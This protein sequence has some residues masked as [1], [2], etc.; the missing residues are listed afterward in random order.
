MFIHKDLIRN[1]DTSSPFGI[2]LKDSCANEKIEVEEK[3]AAEEIN[4][5]LNPEFNDPEAY[6]WL[7]PLYQIDLTHPLGSHQ[8]GFFFVMREQILL[9]ERLAC[10]RSIDKS[11]L[12]SIRKELLRILHSPL[13]QRQKIAEIGMLLFFLDRDSSI[14]PLAESSFVEIRSK[15]IVAQLKRMKKGSAEQ[16]RYLLICFAKLMITSNQ[17]FNRGG[18]AALIRMLQEPRFQLASYFSPEHLEHILTVSHKILSLPQLAQLF[19]KN[20][21]IH[22]TMKLIVERVLGL[23]SEEQIA[24]VHAVWTCLVALFFNIRQKGPNCYAIGSILYAIENSLYKVASRLL[25]FLETGFFWVS[26][27]TSIPLS[28]FLEKRLTSQNILIEILIAMTEF[29]YINAWQDQQFSFYPSLK[30]SLI[31]FLLQPLAKKAITP[32]HCHFFKSLESKIIQM[33]WV[34]NLPAGPL[35]SQKNIER[36]TG[37]MNSLRSVLG[38]C[39]SLFFLHHGVYYP[40]ET[41]SVLI[42]ML[43]FCVA[44]TQEELKVSGFP[45]KQIILSQAFRTRLAGFTAW[46]IKRRGVTRDNLEKAD[47]LFF[48]QTGGLGEAVI[49]N[50]FNLQ[51]EQL[52]LRSPNAYS[53]LH[54]L[55][56]VLKTVDRPAFT[57]SS[58]VLLITPGHHCW[59]LIPSQW[60]FFFE[61]DA[62]FEKVIQT[63]VFDRAH[64]CME[65]L[66]P[67]EIL[68]STLRKC[69]KNDYRKMLDYFYLFSRLTYRDFCDKI[70]ERQ[71]TKETIQA[72]DAEFSKIA[73]IH[74]NMSSVASLLSIPLVPTIADEIE[75][76]LIQKYT[77]YQFP[78]VFAYKIRSLLIHHQIA[79]IDPYRIECAICAQMGLPIPFDFGDLNWVN[80]KKFHYRLMVRYNWALN[81]LSFYERRKKDEVLA[82]K[83][84]YAAINILFPKS[85]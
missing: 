17:K 13:T 52:S 65:A 76:A 74:I 14:P 82:T 3:E 47:L 21:S 81:T 27:Q 80:G 10:E 83:K 26:N 28:P 77:S 20:F 73:S 78:H 79:I 31:H 72:I 58:R 43:E 1:I 84:N 44:E 67:Q 49:A 45:F 41:I 37:D 56:Q 25:T 60:Q 5:L 48:R 4:E 24:S 50:V 57:S 7:S 59:T 55:V 35:Y 54:Q 53:T 42:H 62:C 64:S 71:R 23:S 19:T 51:T 63:K 12:L 40:I 39:Q 85:F 15:E 30:Q 36:F 34:E 11:T 70:L 29:Q 18:I 6:A 66:V 2:P 16:M 22:P 75:R 9:I 69:F 8:N 61:Q 32:A 33:F 38:A 46:E 68:E